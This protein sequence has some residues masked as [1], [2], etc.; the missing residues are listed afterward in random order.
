MRFPP[1]PTSPIARLSQPIYSSNTFTNTDTVWNSGQG[2]QGQGRSRLLGDSEG[3]LNSGFSQKTAMSNS[4]M[5][6]AGAGGGKQSLGTPFTDHGTSLGVVSEKGSSRH[7]GSQYGHLHPG[8]KRHNSTISGGQLNQDRDE[9]DTSESSEEGDSDDSDLDIYNWMSA[10]HDPRASRTTNG[11]DLRLGGTED[12]AGGNRVPSGNGIGN[13]RG[14]KDMKG[15]VVGLGVDGFDGSRR[16]SVATTLDSMRLTEDDEKKKKTDDGVDKFI[17]SQY[18]YS[19]GYPLD[20]LSDMLT[21]PKSACNRK[22]E[23]SVDELVFVGHPVT[24]GPDGKWSYPETEEDN[25]VRPTARGRRARDLPGPSHLGTVIEHGESSP[26]SIKLADGAKGNGNGANAR[27][28]DRQEQPTTSRA[29][30]DDGPPSLNMFH[31]VVILD[32]PDPKSGDQWE[33][34]NQGAAADPIDE[35]YREIAFKWAAAAFDLQVREN[36]IAKQSYEISRTKD[37][38]QNESESRSDLYHMCI[39]AHFRHTHYRVQQALL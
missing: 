18:Q 2:V 5:R 9:S 8:S 12:T 33:N 38:C 6:G 37:K 22:F 3:G 23:I 21:P 19:L 39:L 1:D 34:H 29:S 26:D 32:K 13:R 17:E 14:S 31:L 11:N 10:A 24:C 16:G 7:R 27:A 4:S 35:V 30:S 28:T 25:D 15:S 36:Y 20:F